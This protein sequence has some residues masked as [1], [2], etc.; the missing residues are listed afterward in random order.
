MDFT[1]EASKS[2]FDQLAKSVTRGENRRVV[3]DPRQKWVRD[4]FAPHSTV[5]MCPFVCYIYM[6]CRLFW[7]TLRTSSQAEALL[8]CSQV[9][10]WDAVTGVALLFTALVTIYEVAFLEGGLNCECK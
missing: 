10:G 9:R 1:R 7:R 4:M 3:I 2:H 8:L 5:A 6:S